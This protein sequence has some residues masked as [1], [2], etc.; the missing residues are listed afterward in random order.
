MQRKLFKDFTRKNKTREREKETH[1]R[2]QNPSVIKPKNPKEKKVEVGKEG[3]RRR[4]TMQYNNTECKTKDTNARRRKKK[5]KFFNLHQSVDESD[6]ARKPQFR[7][8]D[9]EI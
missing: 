6:K 1:K 9:S 8:H 4:T 5:R 2:E 7:K 3:T